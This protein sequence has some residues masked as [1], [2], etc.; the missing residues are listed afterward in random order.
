MKITLDF[1]HHQRKELWSKTFRIGKKYHTDET[2]L[3][4]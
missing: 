2:D 4:K 1:I 3:Q